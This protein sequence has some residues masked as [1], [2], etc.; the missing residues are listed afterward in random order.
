M[1]DFFR[2]HTRLALGFMLLLI[3]P[4][5]IFFGVQGYSQFTDGSATTVAKVDG[6]SISRNEWD[7]AHKRYVDQVRRQSP[8]VDIAQIDTP[9][10]RRDTLDG[11]VRDR[12]LIAAANRLQLYP[13]V[14]RMQRLFDS[15][16]QFAGL[17]G[18]DGKIN[19]ELL[20]MQGM[21]PALFDQRLR[22]DLAT[23]QVLAGVT[24]TAPVPAASASAALDAYFQRR[25]VQ[26]QRF[27]PT[28]YRSKVSPTDAEVE[29]YYKANEAQFK[30][31]E[32]ATIE[33]VMLDLDAL[34]KGITLSDADI[35]KAY[36]DGIAKYTVPEERRASHILIK[37]EKD[38]P[39]AER[40]KA[41]AKAQAL[42]ADVRKNPAQFAELARKNSDDP[43]SAAKGG[44][45][46]F[47]GRGAMVKPFE[48][49]IFKLKVG[50][51]SDVVETDFGFHVMTLTAVRGGQSKPFDEVRGAI[52]AEL[53]KA[54]AQSRWAESAELFTNTVYE[55]SDGL[56]PVIDKLKLEKKT[57]TVTRTAPAAAV[58]AKSPLALPKFLDA[59]FG[60]DSLRNK[61]N[62]DA[63][64]VGPNQLIAAHVMQHQ[65][66]RVV[67]YAD[68]KDAA[69]ERVIDTQAAALARKD[70]EARAA[71]L[72][73]NTAEG[74]PNTLTVSRSN[75]QG[76][77]KALLDP[78]MRADA[79]KLP[80]VL[81][82]DLPGQGYVVMRLT[83]VLPREPMPSGDEPLRAQYTQAWAAAEADAYLAALK[84]RYKAEIKPSAN[85]SPEAA[86]SAAR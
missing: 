4:S 19:I 40:E 31:P 27:D 48:D 66:A 55:Q 28:A 62:T 29:A 43:G 49:T 86:S 80:A 16:P 57:A 46:D 9:A 35:R 37:A 54:K 51:I 6:Q 58:A 61:R 64:E 63:L 3:I 67:P 26:F 70:G 47:F 79:G 68:V 75:A 22:Q 45:L 13:T 18:P 44:D 17:R 77:P 10:L 24:Q 76:M 25:E 53:R 41:K 39:A 78:L 71:A 69:R 1:F 23:R 56:K 84:K 82:L 5:F 30:A 42:L 34:A 15:D 60:T 33:Y 72:R 14:G 2:E 74:L 50:E 85:L 38:A 73:S 8:N 12:V 21:S 59:V 52:E 20:A 83:Q 11:L 65:P 7:D 36:D 81:G 32:Q